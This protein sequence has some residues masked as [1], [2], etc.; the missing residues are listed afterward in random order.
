[1]ICRKETN[2]A[3][4]QEAEQHL[5]TK[6]KTT[7][8]KEKESAA[9]SAP[10]PASSSTDPADPHLKEQPS[11]SGLASEIDRGSSSESNSSFDPDASLLKDPDELTEKFVAN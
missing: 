3:K 8:I 2:D 4:A 10:A 7:A 5:H 9:K 11:T 1:M 6:G